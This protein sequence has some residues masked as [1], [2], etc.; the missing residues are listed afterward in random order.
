MFHLVTC[1][2][3]VG[4]SHDSRAPLEC[5]IHPINNNNNKEKEKEKDSPSLVNCCTVDWYTK[6]PVEAFGD[7]SVRTFDTQGA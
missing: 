4:D 1:T 2:S 5:R 3:P 6:W 7:V